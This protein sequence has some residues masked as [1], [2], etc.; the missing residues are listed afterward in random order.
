MAN[1]MRETFVQ[2]SVCVVTILPM[3]ANLL[4]GVLNSTT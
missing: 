2:S 4:D 3:N 1:Q